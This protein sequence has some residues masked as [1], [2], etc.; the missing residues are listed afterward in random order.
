MFDKQVLEKLSCLLFFQSNVSSLLQNLGGTLNVL[1]LCNS[2]CE[3]YNFFWLAGQGDL[4]IHY[5]TTQETFAVLVQAWCVQKKKKIPIRNLEVV[6]RVNL[7]QMHSVFT[8][9]RQIYTRVCMGSTKIRSKIIPSGLLSGFELHNKEH[10]LKMSQSD[11]DLTLCIPRQSS[12]AV[13]WCRLNSV[14]FNSRWIPKRS[15][16]RTRDT[17]GQGDVQPSTALCNS[18]SDSHLP[19]QWG[20]S[21]LRTA[22]NPGSGFAWWSGSADRQLE[23]VKTQSSTMSHTCMTNNVRIAFRTAQESRMT[24]VWC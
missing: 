23:T 20:K 12:K 19:E 4:L 3:L 10:P 5:Y 13:S 9:Q 6:S 22:A 18:L 1:Q 8:V 16:C 14:E 11:S 15:L 21:M 17:R 7:F 2:K 24:T